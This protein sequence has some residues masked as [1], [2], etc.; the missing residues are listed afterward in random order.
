MDHEKISFTRKYSKI[1]QIFQLYESMDPQL[2]YS[3][4]PE[5]YLAIKNAYFH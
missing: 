5:K 4:D 2:S 3:K 1:K